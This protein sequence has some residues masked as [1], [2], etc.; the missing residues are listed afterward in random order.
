MIAMVGTQRAVSLPETRCRHVDAL[1][2]I[3]NM[4]VRTSHRFAVRPEK[5][6]VMRYAKFAPDAPTR[7]SPLAARGSPRKKLGTGGAQKPRDAD[8]WTGLR[9]VVSGI[10][11]ILIMAILFKN[12][13]D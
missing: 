2:F 6:G 7:P 8:L 9:N 1:R 5:A 13:Y 10:C 4:G 12:D 3:I 11:K